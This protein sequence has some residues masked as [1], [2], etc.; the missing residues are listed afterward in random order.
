MNGVVAPVDRG[1]VDRHLGAP[2]AAE[3]AVDRQAGDLAE[4]VPERDVDARDR[5]EQHAAGAA[6]ERAAH[7][8]ASAR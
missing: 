7:G 1:G 3:Q 6:G 2:H 8:A 4:N 5:L